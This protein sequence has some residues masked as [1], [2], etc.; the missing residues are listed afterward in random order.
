MLLEDG[1]SSTGATMEID[2]TALNELAEAGM[3]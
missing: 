1:A 3:V 2:F